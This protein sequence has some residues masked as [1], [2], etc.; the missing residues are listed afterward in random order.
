VLPLALRG[1]RARCYR[2]PPA[3][4][5]IVHD[6]CWHRRGARGAP[7]V[8]LGKRLNLVRRRAEAPPATAR[9]REAS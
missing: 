5:V 8:W 1:D 4:H 9:M 2:E 3:P 7:V 6:W